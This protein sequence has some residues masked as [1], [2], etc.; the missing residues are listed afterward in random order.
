MDRDG[1]GRSDRLR[2]GQRAW[3]RRRVRGDNSCGQGR[4]WGWALSFRNGV[5][6]R[7]GVRVRKFSV[8]II[9]GHPKQYF[10]ILKGWPC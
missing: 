2:L 7:V 1:I 3:A 10:Y 4:D 8:N 5:R 9:L 6:L